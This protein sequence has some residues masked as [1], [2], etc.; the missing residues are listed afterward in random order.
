MIPQGEVI[1]SHRVGTYMGIYINFTRK[2]CVWTFSNSFDV[3][4][5]SIIQPNLIEHLSVTNMSNSCFLGTKSSFF[6]PNSKP[7]HPLPSSNFN[8]TL[9]L[10]LGVSF[11][12]ILFVL[13]I[14][15]L[16]LPSLDHSHSFKP[17]S[18]KHLS[19]YLLWSLVFL[20]FVTSIPPLLVT[21][22][23]FV[24]LLV[25]EHIHMDLKA[26]FFQNFVAFASHQWTIRVFLNIY[27]HA[28]I[29]TYI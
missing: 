27:T 25:F 2:L 7:S 19:F 24:S 1:Q 14:L 10:F 17:H 6:L 20:F 21:L 12:G 11:R 16:P 8:R 4:Y 5:Q 18:L 28:Y 3:N 22:R 26:L 13:E 29:Y 9:K 23:C 15:T